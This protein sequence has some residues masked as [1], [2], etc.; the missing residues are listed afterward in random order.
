MGRARGAETICEHRSLAELPGGGNMSGDHGHHPEAPSGFEA[1]TLALESLLVEKGLIASAAV[2]QVVAAFEQ[3]IGPMRGARAVARAWVDP[4]FKKR[5]VN[6]PAQALAEIGIMGYGVEQLVVVENTPS[7]RNV[8]V[9]TL[10]S[11]YPYSV[12]GLPPTWYKSAPYRSRAVA[13]PRAVLREFG[14][15]VA[16]EVEI[17]VWDSTAEIRYLVLPERPAG[18]DD[19]S[20]V[21]LAEL[22]SRDA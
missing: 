14:V 11:C 18:T 6:N 3:D 12:L 22:V 1:R 7:V 4:E 15:A 10:C 2:D 20:E 16:P 8:I 5:L 13:E 19:W 21:Q 9:C 17:R